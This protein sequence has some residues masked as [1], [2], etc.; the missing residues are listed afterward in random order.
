[1]DEIVRLAARAQSAGNNIVVGAANVPS[2]HVVVG[3]PWTCAAK[4]GV[5]RQGEEPHA[6][7]DLRRAIVNSPFIIHAASGSNNCFTAETN[8]TKVESRAALNNRRAVRRAQRGARTNFKRALRH[9][10]RPGK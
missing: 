10:H 2:P 6:G 1:L 5:T 9:S 4:P 8:G 7:G 3:I